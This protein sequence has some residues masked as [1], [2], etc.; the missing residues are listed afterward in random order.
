MH[1]F[2]LKHP[3]IL[4]VCVSVNISDL[5]AMCQQTLQDFNL[6]M[7]YE[8]MVSVVSS[9]DD[10]EWEHSSPDQP[11]YLDDDIIF[12]II[13]SLISH[14]HLLQKI[15]MGRCCFQVFHFGLNPHDALF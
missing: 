1:L 9:E 3:D 13:A 12:K 11:Q 8:P 14:V 4:T 7:F 6:C 15:G 5:Q 2:A 10:D